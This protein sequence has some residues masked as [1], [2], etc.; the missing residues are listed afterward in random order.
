MEH[1][2][3]TSIRIFIE[4]ILGYDQKMYSEQ[5][6]WIQR[7]KMTPNPIAKAFCVKTPET[8]YKNVIRIPA[9]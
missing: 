3:A 5:A 9:T 1:F 6:F 7:V 2:I 4:K 8:S